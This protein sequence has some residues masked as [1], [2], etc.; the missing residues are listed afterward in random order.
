MLLTMHLS[1]FAWRTNTNI[2]ERADPA[3]PEL[4]SDALFS[5][6]RGVLVPLLQDAIR[7]R[8]RIKVDRANSGITVRQERETSSCATTRSGQDSE[9]ARRDTRGA[10]ASQIVL[11]ARLADHLGHLYV[12][13]GSGCGNLHLRPASSRLAPLVTMIPMRAV[14]TSAQMRAK[15]WALASAT[16][17]SG[18]V[19]IGI[20]PVNGQ[21][22][23][24]RR[25]RAEPD[26]Y[27]PK[28]G[29]TL[30]ELLAR[31]GSPQ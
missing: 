2:H 28:E 14:M 12:R 1:A 25:D 10:A 17:A 21:L 16:Q 18:V 11:P 24:R 31:A 27:A 29:Y 23:C 3:V 9:L 30:R 26:L 5:D 8:R 19:E 4:D 20:D 15:T 22:N 13:L 6:K 7:V